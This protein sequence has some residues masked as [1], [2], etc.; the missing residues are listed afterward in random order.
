M[1]KTVKIQN[2]LFTK[3]D[4]F[5]SFADSRTGR[6]QGKQVIAERIKQI[7]SRRV[8]GGGFFCLVK[9]PLVGWLFAIVGGLVGLYAFIGIIVTILVFLKVVK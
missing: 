2:L 9:L 3:R 6:Y 5:P 4:E 8:F 7:D 1:K